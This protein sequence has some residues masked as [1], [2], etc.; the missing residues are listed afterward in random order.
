MSDATDPTVENVGVILVHGIGEQRRF[1]HLDSQLRDLIRALQRLQESKAANKV[2]H[3]TVDVAPSSAAAFHAEQDTWTAGPE[4]SV[5]IIVQHDLH[6]QAQET[7]LKIHEV[8]WADVNEPY[9][10]AK[11]IRFW[12]WGLSIWL[13]PGKRNSNRPSASLMQ[14]PSVGR[15]LSL[16][17]RVQL[18]LIGVV[19]VLVGYSIG[20]ISF[21]L[22]RLFNLQ[23]PKLL[24]VL[25]NYVSAVK[26]YNQPRRY[27]PGLIPHN[28]EFID[29]VGQPPRVSIR[30]RMMRTIADVACN[31]KYKRWYILAHS[32]GTVVAF[33]GL[34]D[35]VYAWPGYLDEDRWN[36]LKRLGLA[37]PAVSS[38]DLPAKSHRPE[39]VVPPR[40]A[41]VGKDEV[42]YHDRLFDR[43]HG[44]LTYGSPLAKF[45]GIWPGIVQVSLLAAFTPHA[46]W[47]NLYDPIDPVS[48]RLE[49]L[50][51]GPLSPIDVGY[52]AG[53]WLLVSH[54]Q[55]LKQ[56]SAPTSAATATVHW[57]LTDCTGVFPPPL[58]VSGNCHAARGVEGWRSGNWFQWRDAVWWSRTAV[59]YLQWALAATM[60]VFVGAII[61]PALVNAALNAGS[62]VVS[63]LDKFAPRWGFGWLLSVLWEHLIGVGT[64]IRSAVKSALAWSR[65]DFLN[66]MI[67]LAG[68]ALILTILFGVFYRVFVFRRDPDDR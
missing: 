67:E 18:F 53:P 13:H 64:F 44:F 63:Q 33:N 46:K 6:G 65:N 14:P 24:R 38:S 4:A 16:W 3:F 60:L 61:L 32:Q 52:A 51:I 41:W 47:I 23:Q 27:G 8:W 29:A 22:S 54:L 57:L 17:N 48:G 20:T 2:Q 26:L 31:Y 30:R 12:L 68:W 10:L 56:R 1:Q 9:S 37:G 58:K 28:E 50:Q 25:A 49:K 66:R 45:A 35:T 39:E 36:R 55:Y 15:G 11:Q 42:V 19:F 21:L 7:H 40:P 59:A 34:M 5:D 62:A 43:L